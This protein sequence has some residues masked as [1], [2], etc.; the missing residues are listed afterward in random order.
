MPLSSANLKLERGNELAAEVLG[1]LVREGASLQA[2]IDQGG[3]G[4]STSLAFR[5]CEPIRLVALAADALHN[6]RGA[7][8]HMIYAV[9]THEGI[10]RAETSAFPIADDLSGFEQVLAHRLRG[11]SSR[12]QQF[13]AKQCPYRVGGDQLLWALH[14]LNN[15]D[16]HRRLVLMEEPV[17]LIQ[18]VIGVG[19]K[20]S[21]YRVKLGPG[22]PLAGSYLLDSLQQIS[23]QVSAILRAAQVE[24][25]SGA[26]AG[27]PR[28]PNP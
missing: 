24:F 9:I 12:L 3:P 7:L 21:A 11:A 13:V 1:I 23:A 19:I 14:A 10:G 15:I 6:F 20:V 26:P 16:K 25:F 17:V 27:S 8:D 4:V 18:G 22:E 2:A 5:T 28:G